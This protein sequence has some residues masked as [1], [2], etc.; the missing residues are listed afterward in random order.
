ML[1]ENLDKFNA[2]TPDDSNPSATI[3]EENS[4]VKRTTYTEL[5]NQLSGGTQRRQMTCSPDARDTYMGGVQILSHTL[6]TL[7]VRYMGG[8]QILS[9][10]T[11]SPL[12]L[13]T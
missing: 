13:P 1:S 12:V 7:Y 5:Y 3:L 11:R 8:L 2:L 6:H 4:S 9:A 10:G